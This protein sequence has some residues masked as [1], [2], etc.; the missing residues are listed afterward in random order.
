M[1]DGNW[2][3]PRDLESLVDPTLLHAPDELTV[4]CY[5]CPLW[6]RSAMFDEQYGPGWT[7][8]VL[9]Q[10]ARPWFQ[11]HNQPRQ[12]LLGAMDERR[13]E[14]W[15]RYNE[16]ALAHGIDVFIWDWYWYEG[17]P[18]IHEALEE[19]FLRAPN[20]DQMR[21]AVMWTNH[22]WMNLFP[23][24][25][26]DGSRSFLHRHDGPYSLD[27]IWRSISYIIARY[28]HYPNYWRI[29]DKP[30]L[31]IW[32]PERLRSTFGERATMEL[33]NAL[34]DHALRLGHAGI[35]IHGDCT[36]A[37]ALGAGDIRSSVNDLSELGFDTYGLYNPVVVAGTH[38][39]VDEELPRYGHVAAD[40][41]RTVWAELDSVS[42]L[43]CFPSVSTG[44]DSAPRFN[45]VPRLNGG[46]RN[47][48]PGALVVVDETPA[49]FEALVK[50]ALAFLQD[51]PS[52]APILTIGCWNEWTE[53]QY[54]L[55]DTRLGFG[56]LR[57]L[58]RALGRAVDEKS[59]ASPG[60]DEWTAASYQGPRLLAD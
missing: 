7:E 54:M 30:V 18:A 31:V 51:R 27:D 35:H 9:M 37:A 32:D 45:Q 8:Y 19:G 57:A 12:P 60:A 28:F 46:D 34:R 20:S 26:T 24:V 29:A 17:R 55:P 47:T 33:L 48:W 40:I 13:P 4:A 43:P 59:Y 58:A 22:D 2:T 23:N 11:G 53:G 50:A 39:P 25:H 21:F 16:L 36:V 1:T 15:V 42:S 56:M 10:G 14:T 38:R 6:H 5:T 49:A 3:L 44:W 41:V 52:T